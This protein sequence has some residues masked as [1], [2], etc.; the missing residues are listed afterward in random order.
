MLEKVFQEI[1]NKRKFFASSS[2]GEQFEN[3]FRNELKKHFSEINGDL[4]EKL[5]HIEEKP[6][7]EVK[8]AFNQ[9]KKQVL[10]KNHPHTLKNPFS[11]LTSHFLYQPF[12]SQNYPDFLVFI[13]DHVV[14]I[15]IKFSKNDKGEKN[16]QT[17]RPMWNSNLP[18]P[19]AIYVYGVANADITFFKGSDILSYET[20]EVLLKYFDTLDKDEESLKNALKDLENPF[21]FAPYIRKAYEHKKE[22]SNH[23]QIE[24]FFSHN[25]ILREQNVLEFLKTLT[26]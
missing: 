26:H 1:T 9:L 22:F 19:N 12:G 14:G 13:F 5:S 15:E 4:T 17:S 23:H 21:G 16:L 8:T 24:S 3:Q 25:H 6:N 11:N 18:K 2:T 10:E 20:R 7:K